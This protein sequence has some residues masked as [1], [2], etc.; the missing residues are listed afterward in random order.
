MCR[1]FPVYEF[2]R[3]AIAVRRGTFHPT[4]PP[5]PD[6]DFASSAQQCYR[7]PRLLC[8]HAQR[9]RVRQFALSS[10]QAAYIRLVAIGV[11]LH[12]RVHQLNVL[13]NLSRQ[14]VGLVDSPTVSKHTVAG[15]MEALTST[16]WGNM[17]VEGAPP[18]SVPACNALKI[19]G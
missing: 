7:Q 8:A 2:C 17:P 4:P 16:L 5:T 18:I 11:C 1:R 15:G 12:P 13:G 19:A 14:E 3:V 9:F 10:Y 6:L